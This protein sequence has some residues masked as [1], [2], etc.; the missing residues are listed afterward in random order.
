MMLHYLLINLLINLPLVRLIDRKA[1]EG[2]SMVSYGEHN[3]R[4]ALVT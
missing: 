1:T 2:W 3:V 4:I